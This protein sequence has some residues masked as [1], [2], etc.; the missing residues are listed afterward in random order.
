MFLARACADVHAHASQLQYTNESIKGAYAV[1]I[2]E[3]KSGPDVHFK[4]TNGAI[5]VSLWLR[6]TVPRPAEVQLESKNGSVKATLAVRDDGQPLP[7]A[8]RARTVSWG[9]AGVRPEGERAD[10]AG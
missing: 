8:R 3:N 5:R 10:N 2:G 9:G 4:S 1:D 6:G 7:C